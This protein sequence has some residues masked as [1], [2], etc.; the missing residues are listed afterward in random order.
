MLIGFSGFARGGKDTC[1]LYLEQSYGFRRERFA[2]KLKA[3]C[4]DLFGFTAEQIDG[5]LK[6]TPDARYPLSSVCPMC[7]L[8]DVSVERDD[9]RVCLSCA[10]HLPSHLT[11]RLAMQQIGEGMRRLHDGVWVD[12]TVRGCGDGRVAICDVRFPNEVEAIRARGGKVVRLLR[13]Q[14]QS[15]HVSEMALVGRSELFDVVIDNRESSLP[16]LHARLDAL[17][18]EWGI[19]KP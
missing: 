17:M 16:E 14:P 3:I 2:A 5:S 12:A 15:T 11:P 10:T 9:G 8:A 4:M 19:A 13:G 18:A 7:G 6:E 1:G